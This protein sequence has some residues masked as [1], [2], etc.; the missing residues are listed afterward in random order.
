MKIIGVAGQM[1]AGKDT[2]SDY[3]TTI[4]GFERASF[5]ANVKRV[6]CETFG[7]NLE[8]VEKWKVIPE[9]PP[10]F[11]ST[12][13]QGLQQI[14]D[15][16]RKIK[17][18]IWVELVFRVLN[19]NIVISDGRYINELERIR[20]EKGLNILVWRPGYENNDPNGS[21]AQLKPVLDYFAKIG[22][23]GD[24]RNIGRPANAPCGAEFVDLFLINYGSVQ[25]LY[26]KVD[27][28][29]VSFLENVWIVRENVR[30]ECI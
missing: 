6:F 17:G 26:E 3:L 19:K 7:V 9:V 22:Q 21:E 25:D 30:H 14:G 20:K 13:R 28:L 5:A 10:G 23:E 18:D 15:G 8:F 4:I 11:S 1:R 2:I 29:V 16:F 12:V 27:K 24:V